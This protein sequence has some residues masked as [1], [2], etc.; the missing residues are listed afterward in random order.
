MTLD[1]LSLVELPV[2]ILFLAF[3]VFSQLRRPVV[4]STVLLHQFTVVQE[5]T[6]SLCFLLL[7]S[8]IVTASVLSF[9]SLSLS[10]SLFPS[11]SR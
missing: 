1:F 4:L 6:V 7:L 9:R 3:T 5:D 11:V 8:L 10:S 2:G